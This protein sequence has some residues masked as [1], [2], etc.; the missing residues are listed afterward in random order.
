MLKFVKALIIEDQTEMLKHLR[1]CNI[2]RRKNRI[3]FTYMQ[4]PHNLPG[5]DLADVRRR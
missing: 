4:F 3:H 5:A 1:K 2:G